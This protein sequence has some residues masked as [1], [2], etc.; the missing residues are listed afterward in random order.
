MT[1]EIDLADRVALVT[2]GGSGIGEAIAM[3]LAE[4]GA[5]VAVVDLAADSAVRVA[6]AIEAKGGRSVAVEADVAS[7]ASVAAAHERVNAE[8]GQVSLLVNNAA[9]WVVKPFADYSE[10]ETRRVVDVTLHGTIAVT[11]AFLPDVVATRGVIVMTASDGARVGEPYLSVY[12]AA[13]AGVIGLVKSLAKE[14]GKHGVRVNAVAPGTTK[15]PG[16]QAFIES[17]GGEYKLA[18]AYPLRRLGEP[19]DIANA[20]LFLVAPLS[21]WVTGQ[22]LSVSGG[23][24][25]A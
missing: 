22:V 21:S 19:Q 8:L 16:S 2:G 12:I 5:A 3:T 14:V 9:I 4:A 11:R 23:Y 6:D 13:K 24:T 15:T 1:I 25:M 10:E 18:R 17:A 20:V 7:T